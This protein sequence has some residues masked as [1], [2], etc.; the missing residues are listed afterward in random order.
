M[1][2]KKTLYPGTEAAEKE[3]KAA[4]KRYQE[5][6]DQPDFIGGKPNYS[7]FPGWDPE[8][9]LVWLNID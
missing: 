3:R 4:E 1:K 8:K 7:K 5:R 9:V 2:R 6:N